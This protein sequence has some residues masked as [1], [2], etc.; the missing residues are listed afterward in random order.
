MDHPSNVYGKPDTHECI[1]IKWPLR[2]VVDVDVPTSPRSFA[3]ASSSNQDKCSWH[4]VYPYTCF[5][6]YHD[7]KGFVEKVI[8]RVG[9]PYADFIDLELYKSCFSL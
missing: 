3:L 5:V 8:E 6:D 7:L 2:L 9:R 4:I 1:N